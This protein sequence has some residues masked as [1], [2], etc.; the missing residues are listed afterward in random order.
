MAQKPKLAMYWASSCGGCEIAV[1]NLN[2]KLLALDANFDFV[3]CPCLLDTKISEIESLADSEIAV[4]LF[5]GA[6]RTSENEEM[7]QLLRRKSQLLVAFGSCA[8]E[9]CIP[10]LS[11]LSSTACHLKT[12]YLEN[13]SIENPTDCIP[14]PR[15]EV[16]EGELE[17]PKFYDQVRC[18]SDVVEVDYSIPGCPPEP[19]QIWSVVEALIRVAELPPKGSVLG[20]GDSTVCDQCSRRKE[21][22]TIKVLNR[23][24][25]VIPDRERCLFEQGI[26]CMGIATRDGCGALCPQVN[27]PCTGCYGPPQGVRDQGAKMVSALGSMLDMDPIKGVTDEQILKHIDAVIDQVPDLAGTFYKYSLAGSLLGGKV[28]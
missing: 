8:A 22:K 11:N 17:L 24:Y 13:A 28:Q 2:E 14:Q 26:I 6:I 1:V 27:M 9:G 5:N 23:P 16:P 3:F 20:A 19:H 12:V 21:D 7:A 15:T 4:T 25:E 18:L 10:A